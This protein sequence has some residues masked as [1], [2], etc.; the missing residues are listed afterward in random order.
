MVRDCSIC[1]EKFSN[2]QSLVSLTTCDHIFHFLCMV[3]WLKKFE[4]VNTTCPQCLGSMKVCDLRTIRMNIRHNLDAT[5]ERM[6]K[7]MT[8][9][10]CGTEFLNKSIII[11]NLE[12]EH[13]E[14]L[15]QIQELATEIMILTIVTLN[16][17]RQVAKLKGRSKQSDEEKKSSAKNQ[18]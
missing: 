8:I 9:A 16:L 11:A 17:K 1:S 14:L 10:K 4:D 5:T 6:F 7:K 18:D 2:N 15:E 13:D 3:R 12:R